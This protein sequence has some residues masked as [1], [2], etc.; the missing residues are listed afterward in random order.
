MERRYQPADLSA[1]IFRHDEL[2]GSHRFPMSYVTPED[3]RLS[4]SS[5]QK[6]E[7]LSTN[8]HALLL[9]VNWQVNRS[10]IL[11]YRL[12]PVKYVCHIPS[13]IKHR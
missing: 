7:N 3:T 6:R 1:S 2:L 12:G 8:L 10:Q 5:G 13:K 9:I 11:R 4:S